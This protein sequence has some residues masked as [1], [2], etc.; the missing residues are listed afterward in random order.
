MP[1]DPPLSSFILP[2]DIKS[3]IF[4]FYSFDKSYIFPQPSLSLDTYFQFYENKGK[5]LY[6]TSSYSHYHIY[7]NSS[8]K[9]LFFLF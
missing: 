2:F 8:K 4:K 5:N 3:L 7:K 1:H 6:R 9:F